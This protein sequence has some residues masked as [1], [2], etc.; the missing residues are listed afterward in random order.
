MFSGYVHIVFVDGCNMTGITRWWCGSLLI[1]AL[2]APLGLLVANAVSQEE[3][4]EA[5]PIVVKDEAPRENPFASREGRERE[6]GE[7]PTERD[8]LKQQVE[9]FKIALHGLQEAEKPDAADVLQRAIR[10]REVTLEGRR[11]DEAHMIRERA[12]SRE[13]LAKVLAMAAGVWR[14]FNNQEKAA[15]VGRLA[16]QLASRPGDR[17]PERE[18]GEEQ[19]RKRTERPTERDIV[20]RRIEVMKTAMPALREGERGDAVELLEHAIRAY[21]VGLEGRR[22]D[23]AH[24]IRER[25]PKPGHLAESLTMAS[26]L[27]REFKDE[28]KAAVVGRLAKEFAGKGE[29]ERERERPAH[30]GPDA[31]RDGLRNRLQE[32]EDAFLKAREAGKEDEAARL[33]HQM[34]DLARHLERRPTRRPAAKSVPR[35]RGKAEHLRRSIHELQD[36][37]AEMRRQMAEMQRLIKALADQKREDR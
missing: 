17:K 15:V 13:H 30:R 33:R 23:E 14:E 28:E 5:Q 29:R 22:D 31:E 11:D 3:R 6:R 26:N 32:L 21:E 34:E 16:E 37:M 18:R 36:Q 8:I 24:R 25:M 20:L 4:E 10:A 1:V 7:R 27:W 35:E 19:P 12:P 2:V 9:V